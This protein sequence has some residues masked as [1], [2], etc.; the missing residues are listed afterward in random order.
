MY[1]SVYSFVIH[2]EKK[3]PLI[4]VQVYTQKYQPESITAELTMI[5]V[6]YTEAFYSLEEVLFLISNLI[7]V[8][9]ILS[10][11]MHGVFQPNL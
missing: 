7:Q 10:L 8:Y 2:C 3:R 11:S 9:L 4:F 5:Y 6:M 1:L